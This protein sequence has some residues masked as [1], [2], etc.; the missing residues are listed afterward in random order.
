MRSVLILK[1]EGS[2]AAKNKQYAI[3]I[4]VSTNTEVHDDDDDE[5]GGGGSN[6]NSDSIF[7]AYLYD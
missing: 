2:V 6:G 1:E 4:L 3:Y 5:D 7:A